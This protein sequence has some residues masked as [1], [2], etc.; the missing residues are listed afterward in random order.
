MRERG[1]FPFN[2]NVGGQIKGNLTKTH[3]TGKI[4]LYG[5]YLDDRVTQY[6]PIPFS[7]LENLTTY[8][9]ELGTFDPNYSSTFPSLN[10]QIPDYSFGKPK[11]ATRDFNSDDGIDILT[12]SVGLEITQDLGEWTIVNNAKYTRADQRYLQYVANVVAPIDF[13]LI[14]LGYTSTEFQS[15]VNSNFMMQKRANYCS[16]LA[17]RE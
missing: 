8:S 2:A 4:K 3:S 15:Q 5:K 1:K 10:T 13:A 6:R 11:G 9:N 14:G 7:D 17:K 12:K 16:T